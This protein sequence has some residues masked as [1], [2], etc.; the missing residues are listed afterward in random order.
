[1]KRLTIFLFSIFCAAPAFAAELAGVRLWTAPD[2]TRLVFDTSGAAEHKVFALQK[3]DRLVID[4][5]ETRAAQDFSVAGIEDRHLSRIRHAPRPDGGLRVVLDL[6]QRV[7][8]KTFHLKPNA[9]YGHRVVVDLYPSEPAAKPR[10]AKSE[11]DIEREKVL[12]L[13]GAVVVVRIA[14]AVRVERVGQRYRVT[15][16]TA[17]LQRATVA[18]EVVVGIAIG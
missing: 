18:A 1:M 3:P 14:V 12:E 4:F 5:A 7:R 6:N 16:A 2:H 13:G 9:N 15:P 11:T 17:D 10:V 8:P